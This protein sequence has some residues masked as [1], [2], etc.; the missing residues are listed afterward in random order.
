M[1]LILP[2]NY[3]EEINA[4]AN[5][6][7]I[8]GWDVE[9]S[10]W[11]ISDDLDRQD[12]AVYGTEFFCEIIANQMNWKLHFNPLDWL[13]TLPEEY[14][15]RKISFMKFN[16]ARN[17]KEEKFIKPADDKAFAAKVY[18]S[19]DELDK[20]PI[21][22]DVP[23]LVSDVM[24]FTSEYR[25]FIKD[26]NVVSICCYYYNPIGAAKPFINEKD[27]YYINNDAVAAFVK[28]LLRDK[29]VTCAAG[30]VIDVGRFKKDT[31]AV[32]ESNPA[33]A[34]E[35]YGCELVGTLDAIKSS[36]T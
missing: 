23:V 31:Y 26:N 20:N 19:G 36:C 24:K 6:A 18:K 1:L 16:T 15:S 14:V 25:C 2:Q 10:G 21:L 27:N 32:I 3:T 7:S 30:S 28:S 34:S 22:D 9:R 29:R 13:A 35:L 33:Y 12:G 5:T 4:L 17:I 8:L 11:N